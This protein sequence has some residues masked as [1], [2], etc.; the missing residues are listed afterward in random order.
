MRHS[1]LTTALCGCASER[2]R[3]GYPP[4]GNLLVREDITPNHKVISCGLWGTTWGNAYQR[5]KFYIYLIMLAKKMSGLS[6]RHLSLINQ[7]KIKKWRVIPLLAP[8]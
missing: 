4:L 3:F 2:Q 1:G 8:R 7:T 5:V 6:L